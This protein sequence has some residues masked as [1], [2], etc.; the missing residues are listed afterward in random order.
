ML[1]SLIACGAF[2]S[3]ERN[4]ARLLGALDDVLRWASAARRGARR[5]RSSGLFAAARRRRRRDA[6]AAARR[7]RPGRPRRSCRA[8][9]RGARLLH[10]RP[11]ARPL[12]A[13]P[14]HASRTSP[15]A[16]C[17][18]AAPQLPAASAA[19]RAPRAARACG[20]AASSTRSGSATRRRATA[21]P[22]SCSRTRRAWSR[23]SPGRTPTGGTRTI[24]AAASRWS[25]AGGLDIAAER[26]QIIAEE[27][28][29]LDAARAEAIQQVHVRVPLARVGRDELRAPAR[30]RWPSTRV[31]ATAFLH[32]LRPDG[33]RDHPRAARTRSGSRPSDEVARC[34]RARARQPACCRSVERRRL[35]S[36]R[37]AR[38]SARSWSASTVPQAR[39]PVDGVAGRARAPRRHRRA[40]WSVGADDPAAPARPSRHLHRRRQGRGGARPGRRRERPTSSSSTIRSRPAQQRNLEK[41]LGCKVIDRS[42]LIL[43]IFAQRARSLEGKLQVEL[44]QLQY[45]LPRLTRQWTHLSRQRGGGVGTRGPGETQL[46]V[47]RRRV[48][49]RIARAAPAARRRRAHARACIAPSA[50]PSPF[51]TVALVGY[52][53]AGKSTLMNALTQRGRAG[54]GPAL[55]DARPDRAPAPAAGRASPSLLADTVGFIHK[56]PHQLVEAFKSTLEQVRTADL[57][58]H[59]VDASHPTL[60]GARA[61]SSR[62]CW[63]RSA[64][65]SVP[66]LHGAEQDRPA[67]PAAAPPAAAGAT[68]SLVSARTG[69]GRRRPAGARSRTALDA[70]L[71]RVRC[72]LP[73]GPRRRRRLAPPRRPRRSRST[74]ATA[75]VTVTALVPPK[76]AGQ[77]RKAAPRRTR[78]ARVLTS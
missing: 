51:P 56:L 53:N 52:T 47:D 17:A 62:R 28:M 74:T 59:V 27:I 35:H 73:V 6:A 58:L 69:H 72:E 12:R 78:G 44:A 9:A 34:R 48:R 67:C 39:I 30:R 42:A 22:R 49:E 65:A 54:R 37:A 16:R 68:R 60:A 26:C 76:V 3:V 36:D 55:R 66:A 21:T 40:R 38:R 1:E 4:R 31:R 71:A 10:H 2:D 24:V 13:G 15:S 14:A 25:S 70:G 57:L 19:A 32:L 45:L 29:P 18:R 77:L 63:T 43:D 5:A 11:P 33:H 20:S 23:S 61:A 8:R 41:A 7:R 64:P 46:E 75:S 50:R